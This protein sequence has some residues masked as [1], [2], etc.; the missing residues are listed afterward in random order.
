MQN[1]SLHMALKSIEACMN[2]AG[3]VALHDHEI[4]SAGP[5]PYCA[6]RTRPIGQHCFPGCPEQQLFLQL[7][8]HPVSLSLTAACSL[9]AASLLIATAAHRH[10]AV[11]GNY[12]T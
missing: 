12:H 11:H 1:C 5:L 6:S 2:I 7:S 8:V 10:N 4:T 9:T 3:Q